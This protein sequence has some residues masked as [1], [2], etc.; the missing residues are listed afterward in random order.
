MSTLMCYFPNDIQLITIPTCG[1]K[2]KRGRSLEEGEVEVDAREY[3]FIKWFSQFI[4]VQRNKSEVFVSHTLP[5]DLYIRNP[6]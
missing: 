5:M 1:A 4:P 2:I 6:L 3:D